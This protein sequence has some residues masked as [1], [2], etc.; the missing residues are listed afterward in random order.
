[1][2]NGMKVVDNMDGEKKANGKWEFN[3][4]VFKTINKMETTEPQSSNNTRS[5]EKFSIH[6]TGI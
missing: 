1:M 2:K 5:K 6:Y 3:K 4:T